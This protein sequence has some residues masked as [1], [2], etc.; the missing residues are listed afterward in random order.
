M[1][2]FFLS[3]DQQNVVKA[4]FFDTINGTFVLE[5]LTLLLKIGETYIAEEGFAGMHAGSQNGKVLVAI[6]RFYPFPVYRQVAQEIFE[7][8]LCVYG[9]AFEKFGQERGI[10]TFVENEPCTD[11][12]HDYCN[13]FVCRSLSRYMYDLHMNPR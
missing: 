7:N 3:L 1:L 10:E 2:R 12:L 4:Q 8:G 11:I 9:I 6:S 5:L 13:F